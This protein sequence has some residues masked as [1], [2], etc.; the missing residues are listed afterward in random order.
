MLPRV[1]RCCT[2]ALAL[3]GVA[4]AS[5]VAQTGK[6]PITTSSLAARQAYLDG[7]ALLD[8]LRAQD[9]RAHFQ[10]AVAEDPSF[11]VAHLQLAFTEPTFRGFFDE[12]DRAVALAGG[13]SEGEQLWIRGVK[14]GTDGRAMDQRAAYRELV[15]AHPGDERSHA[16][17]GNHFFAQQEYE[18]AT[19]SFEEAIRLDPT[20][21]QPYNQLGYAYRFR[22]NFERAEKTFRKYIELIPDDPNPYDSYAELLMKMGRYDESIASYRQALRVAPHFAASHIGIASDLNY[23]GK[24]GEARR[25]LRLFYKGARTDGERRAALQATAVSF[26]DQGDLGGALEALNR[27]YRIAEA[28]VDAAAMAAD[29]GFMGDLLLDAG[30]TAVAQ[31]AFEKAR[32]LVEISD[33]SE[34]VKANNRRNYLYDAARVDIANG[35][36]EAARAKAGKYAVGARQMQNGFFMRLGHELKAAIALAAGDGDGALIALKLANQQDPYNLYRTAQAYRLKGDEKQERAWLERTTGFNSL[37]NF[38]YA[39]VRHRASRE[40]STR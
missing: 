10:R 12:L 36:L 37:N 8:K 39:L 28:S 9:S 18:L 17:L 35:E 40:S 7:R 29:L 19:A 33:L 20:F 3:T 11:A 30:S 16:L 27:Q 25:Q 4:L 15:S 32:D 21:S 23:L 24:H 14:A 26:M 5:A 22:G 38:N 2:I 34:Q 31:A 13:T 1:A 6:I